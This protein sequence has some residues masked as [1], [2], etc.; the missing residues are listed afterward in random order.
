MDKGSRQREGRLSHTI[1]SSTGTGKGTSDGER[2]CSEVLPKIPRRRF[3]SLWLR[4]KTF[5]DNDSNSLDSPATEV[6]EVESEGGE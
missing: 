3:K 2:M 5:T 1:A 4:S 6:S